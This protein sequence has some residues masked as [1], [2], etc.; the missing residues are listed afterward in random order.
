M[1]KSDLEYENLLS[2][3]KDSFDNNDGA[4]PDDEESE[5]VEE[6]IETEESSDDVENVEEELPIDELD[7][8]KEKYQLERKK[9]KSVLADRQRLEQ[10]NHQLKNILDGTLNN[11]SELYGRDLYNDL[12]KIKN[13]KKHALLGDDPDLLIE[14]DEIYQKTL[15]KVNEFESAISRNSVKNSDDGDGDY[16]NYD[17]QLKVA[18]AQ[19]WVSEHPELVENSYSYNPK[20]HREV[21][22]FIEHFDREL[23]RNG[24]EDE[25]LTDS[26]LEV[27]EEFIEGVKVQRPRD[28][29][30]TS[31][32]GAVRNNFPSS[33]G[34]TVKIVLKDYEKDFARSIGISEQQLIKEK[35]TDMKRQSGGEYNG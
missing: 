31:N 10:E 16:E 21:G 7:L 23:K 20:I 29:Y 26:Y 8:F 35:I 30:R 13:I 2:G 18:K 14:A 28:G 1:S 9:R 24:R 25:I 15:Y 3:I 11:N 12:E 6:N 33:T 27:L 19:E 32:V 4:V 34:S 17:E 22:S 5:A